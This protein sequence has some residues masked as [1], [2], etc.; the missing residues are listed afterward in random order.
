MKHH[1]A[2][3]PQGK[4]SH[5]L[6]HET[7]GKGL[8]VEGLRT[9]RGP[10]ARRQPSLLQQ[11]PSPPSLPPC[12]IPCLPCPLAV[13]PPSPPWNF[14]IK[15]NLKSHLNPCFSRCGPQQQQGPSRGTCWKCR[16]L[17]S[18]PDLPNQS[19]PSNRRIPKGFVCTV[20]FE[21][22]WSKLQAAGSFSIYHD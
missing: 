5:C 15:R 20:E 9:I 7:G 21:K 19:L 11:S 17:S 13:Y 12:F 10:V 1:V 16:V 3:W 4:G 22:H 8:Q 2:F 6:H 18:T 14:R